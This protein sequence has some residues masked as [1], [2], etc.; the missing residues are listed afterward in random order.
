MA[1]FGVLTS[2]VQTCQRCLMMFGMEQRRCLLTP[3]PFREYLLVLSVT[4]LTLFTFNSEHCE[5]LLHVWLKVLP[6]QIG[7]N[8][9]RDPWDPDVG[10][11]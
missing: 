6:L 7:M 8:P 5:H 10:Y 2:K 4:H 1:K 3:S 11:K 9:K